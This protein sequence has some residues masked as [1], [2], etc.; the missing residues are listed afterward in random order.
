MKSHIASLAIAASVLGST[1]AKL[2]H[3]RPCHPNQRRHLQ[4]LQDRPGLAGRAPVALRPEP[5]CTRTRTRCEGRPSLPIHRQ[6]RVHDRWAGRQWRHDPRYRGD[7]WFLR[8]L[9]R[10]IRTSSGPSK[11]GYALF[12]MD[13]SA[14]RNL[15][16]T[17][18]WELGSSPSIVVIDKGY[19]NAL[20]NATLHPRTYAFFF[21]QRGLMGELAFSVRRSHAS[22]RSHDSANHALLPYMSAAC[23][24]DCHRITSGDLVQKAE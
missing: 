19:S 12:F 17:G 13:D 23:H 10:R 24:A 22:I 11:S 7:Q 6:G 2:R 18:G 16:R 3:H 8:K 5:Q 4:R 9:R 1:T 14:Y 20:T 21:D 15:N